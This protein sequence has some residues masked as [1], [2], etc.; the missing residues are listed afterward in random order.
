MTIVCNQFVR[1]PLLTVGQIQWADRSTFITIE[2]NTK[3]SVQ[4]TFDHAIVNLMSRIGLFL[5]D[6]RLR[7]FSC[8]L[9]PFK[10]LH[11]LYGCAEFRNTV[12]I[13]N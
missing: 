2:L 12:W 11:V 9:N 7:V 5:S 8:C 4:F 3:L 6:Y 10:R 1:Y 13:Q